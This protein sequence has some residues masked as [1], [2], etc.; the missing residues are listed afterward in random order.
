MRNRTRASGRA[1]DGSS[2]GPTNSRDTAANTPE[3][4]RSRA[5]TADAAFLD[6][7][8]SPFT[9][10]DTVCRERSAGGEAGPVKTAGCDFSRELSI[11]I[12]KNSAGYTSVLLPL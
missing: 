1:A 4:G 10:N 7:I 5:R 11:K 3:T 12:V 2:R 9:P 6:P 8:T